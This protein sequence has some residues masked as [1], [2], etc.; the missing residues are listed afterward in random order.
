MVSSTVSG[1]KVYG[2]G[3]GG[4]GI[5]SFGKVTIIN[6]TISGN[7]AQYSALGGGIQ[8]S[9]TMTV[10]NSTITGNQAPCRQRKTAY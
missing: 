6:S 7:Q 4:G 10:T 2:S 3:N 9:G 8:N 5:S 1:N